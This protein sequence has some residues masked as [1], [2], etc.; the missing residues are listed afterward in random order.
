[1]VGK[2]RGALQMDEWCSLSCV[3]FGLILTDGNILFEPVVV[4]S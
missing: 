3:P 4:W 2:A 1:M